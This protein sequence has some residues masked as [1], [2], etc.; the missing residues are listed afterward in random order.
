MESVASKHIGLSLSSGQMRYS[1]QRLWNPRTEKGLLATLRQ[2]GA[3]RLVAD[4]LKESDGFFQN[5]E[6]ACEEVQ[7]ARKRSFGSGESRKR[8]W[9]ELRIRKPELV[10]DTITLPLQRVREAV[11]ELIKLSEDKEIGETVMSQSDLKEAPKKLIE[12][13]NERGGDDNITVIAVERAE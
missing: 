10:E 5:V 6:A 12:M 11:S 13:A 2:G 3:V 1:L 9:T 7:A 4:L 8:D